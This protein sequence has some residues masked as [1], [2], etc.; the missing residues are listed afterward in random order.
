M[1]GDI[2]VILG[3]MLCE[4]HFHEGFAVAAR[5][6]EVYLVVVGVSHDVV[7]CGKLHLTV[8]NRL[9]HICR[10]RTLRNVVEVCLFT[11]SM[12]C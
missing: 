11:S 12:A 5:D 3:Y 1:L 8:M 2:Y 6:L 4:I 9:H 10:C 7:H